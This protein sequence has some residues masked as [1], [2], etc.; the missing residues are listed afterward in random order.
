MKKTLQEH[1]QNVKLSS[2]KKLI[3][4][5]YIILWS[6]ISI[7]QSQQVDY[8]KPNDP[9]YSVDESWK[10]S[11]NQVE[12]QNM[13][14]IRD[15]DSTAF[16]SGFAMQKIFQFELCKAKKIQNCE[17]LGLDME[18]SPVSVMARCKRDISDDEITK[19]EG[20]LF[21]LP[22]SG[23]EYHKNI[24]MI[25]GCS[26]GFIALDT[27]MA[28]RYKLESCYPFDQLANR[29]PIL[30][31][32][33]DFIASRKNIEKYYDKY[34]TEGSI[35]EECFLRDVKAFL[36]P[37]VG[38]RSPSNEEILNSLKKDSYNKMW[39]S[40]FNQDECNETKLIPGNEYKYF[41]VAGSPKIDSYQ[42]IMDH[43]NEAVVK[44]NKPMV[45]GI[46][47]N[48]KDG[49]C[50]GSHAFVI[51]GFDRVCKGS[52][53]RDI[54]KVENSWG[55]NWYPRKSDGSLNKWFD[56]KELFKYA[57]NDTEI[58]WIK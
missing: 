29:F 12:I 32:Q 18:I 16:C 52:Q 2:M 24:S 46:C 50:L 26:I 40:L 13:P 31:R 37:T 23:I 8:S 14:R 6:S 42:K 44:N 47:L 34:K 45:I 17:G 10:P 1:I 20:F 28:S 56:A 7:S 27:R 35:C 15:Q 5:T 25:G 33:K 43:I 36:Y 3:Y 21:Q 4:L 54:V 11:S 51:S 53:C 55:E 48:K 41:P 30:T 39:Y 49:K 38:M 58:S 19:K 57:T 9:F 22:Y